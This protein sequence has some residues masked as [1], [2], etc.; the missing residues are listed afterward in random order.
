MSR[1]IPSRLLALLLALLFA[2]GLATTLAACGKK[3]PLESP[4]GK[5]SDYPRQYPQ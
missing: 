5:E 3:G 1:R 2:F 4:S